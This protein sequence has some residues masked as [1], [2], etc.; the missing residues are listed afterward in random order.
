M[1]CVLVIAGSDPLGGAGI[2][3][4]IKTIAALG[5]H[6]TTVITSVTVQNSKGVKKVHLIPPDFVKGQLEA[7]MED[8]EPKAVKIGMVADGSITRTVAGLIKQYRLRPV[9]LDPV[10]KASSGGNLL[11]PS[12]IDTLKKELLPL[13]SVVTPNIAEAEILAEMIIRDREDMVEAAKRIGDGRI[14]VVVT[15]GHLGS[16]SPDLVYDSGEVMWIEGKRLSIANTHGTGCVFSSALAVFMAKGENLF[17]ATKKAHDFTRFAIIHSYSLGK[18][19]GP[20]NPLWRLA[21]LPN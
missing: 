5:A 20:V 4:D 14:A 17:E 8:V 21:D 11:D 6:A 2:Q 3:A 7:I 19:I 15:G 16:T 10:M 18:G 1:K 12:A 13:A 9:V